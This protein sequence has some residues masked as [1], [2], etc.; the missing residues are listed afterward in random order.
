M[1]VAGE[2][3]F[4]KRRIYLT[5]ERARNIAVRNLLRRVYVAAGF[6][7]AV[8]DKPPVRR[9]RL[10]FKEFAAALRIGSKTD[11]EIDEV[12]CVLGNMIS[13]VSDLYTLLVL[14]PEATGQRAAGL[15]EADLELTLLVLESDQGIYQPRKGSCDLEQERIG[16]PRDG[17]VI[18]AALLS[19]P[20]P[21]VR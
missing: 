8:D 3:E 16:F 10:E 17:T 4:V 15:V 21:L 20:I 9:S 18:R 2:D 6:E 11:V 19:A 5:L 7:P 13:K 1:L 12:E 14:M